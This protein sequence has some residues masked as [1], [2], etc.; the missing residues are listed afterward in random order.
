MLLFPTHEHCSQEIL[1]VTRNPRGNQIQVRKLERQLNAMQLKYVKTI[2]LS[3][4]L[5]FL[6]AKLLQTIT[7]NLRT[8][9]KYEI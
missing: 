2:K 1:V 4:L 6:F 9:R 3:T 5:H 7:N 8:N